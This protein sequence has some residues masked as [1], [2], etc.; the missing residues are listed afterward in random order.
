MEDTRCNG[1]SDMVWRLLDANPGVVDRYSIV[2]QVEVGTGWDFSTSWSGLGY[3]GYV[4]S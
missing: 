1:G 4:Y 2:Q 3:A